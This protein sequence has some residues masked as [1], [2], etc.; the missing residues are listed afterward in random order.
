MP[1]G[2]PDQLLRA[3]AD[4]DLRGV[5][6][7]L[8]SGVDVNAR[9]EFGDS[10]LNIAA[11]RGHKEIVER[12]I[13]AG[14]NVE[15]LGGAD[16]TPI[17]NAAVAG[18]VGIVRL[19][20]EKGAWISNDLINSVHLKVSILEENAEGGMVRPEAVEAWRSFLSFLIEA[21]RKAESGEG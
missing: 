15:N 5:N 18:D 12:L 2:V 13:A 17:M 3:A 10:A 4:G 11:Q 8:E 14:A 6:A 9:G 21:R 7:A 19:L 20:L 16:M 1:S